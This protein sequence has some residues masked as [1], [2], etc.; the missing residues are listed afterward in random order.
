MEYWWTRTFHKGTLTGSQC[1][2]DH[3]D[4]DAAHWHASTVCL[5][6]HWFDLRKRNIGESFLFY[7]E[8]FESR[9]QDN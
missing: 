1:W 3:L 4:N 8:Q 9:V 5:D 6:E 7:V 2:N